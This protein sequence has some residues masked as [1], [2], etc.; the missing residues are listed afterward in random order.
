MIKKIAILLIILTVPMAAFAGGSKSYSCDTKYPVILAHGMGFTDKMFGTIEYFWGVEDKLRDE[1]GTV[2]A[3]KVNCMDSTQAKALQFKKQFLQILAITGKS[4]ANIIGHSHG[5]IYTRYAITNLG[6]GSKV[7][8]HTSLCG[9]HQGSKLADMIVGIV[10]DSWESFIG[11]ITD[12]IYILLLGD[13]NPSSLE[14]AY[15]VTTSYM[16]NVFNPSTPNYSGIYYQSWAT[17]I[18]YLSPDLILQPSWIIM[19][20]LEGNNDGL[21]ST[22]SARWGNFRGVESGAWWGGGVSHATAIG[23]FFGITPGFNAPDFYKGIVKDLKNR[24]F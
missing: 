15:A 4:K 19:K 24:N 2:F 13:D 18:K 1:G 12:A 22:T 9:P 17:K 3:T 16:K 14:N 7:A 10:P 20:F 21:V 8:S 5:T 11:Q 6:L 23:H